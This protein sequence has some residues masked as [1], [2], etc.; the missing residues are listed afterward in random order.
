MSRRKKSP[1]KNSGPVPDLAQTDLSSDSLRQKPSQEISKQGSDG[2]QGTENGE[3]CSTE[4]FPPLSIRR[5]LSIFVLFHLVAVAVSMTAVGAS[6]QT[7]AWLNGV[8]QPYTMPTHFRTQGERVYLA[9]GEAIENPHQLQV[10]YVSDATKDDA[11]GSLDASL[12]WEVMPSQGIPGLAV[13]DR[14]ARWISTMV[15][16]IDSGSPSLIAELLLPIIRSD[17]S[18]LAVRIVRLPTQLSLVTD[19]EPDPVYVAAVARSSDSVSLVRIDE[20]RLRTM[21]RDEGWEAE[22][23]SDE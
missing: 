21:S 10:L 4:N 18:I 17:D 23:G 1:K 11:I 8:L 7:Q 5:L 19:A 3:R 9:S 2:R 16:L 22:G 15:T 20:L 6:S 13:D 14:Y 12:A